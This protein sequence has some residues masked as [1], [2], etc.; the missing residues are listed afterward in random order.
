VESASGTGETDICVCV[1]LDETIIISQ[2]MTM[3]TKQITNATQTWAGPLARVF[4]LIRCLI[5]PLPAFFPITYLSELVEHNHVP[6]RNSIL[7]CTGLE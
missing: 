6:H 4:A 3:T 5:L 7:H 1:Q 2:P